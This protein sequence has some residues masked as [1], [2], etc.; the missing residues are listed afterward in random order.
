M[1]NNVVEEELVLLHIH[2]IVK[3]LDQVLDLVRLDVELVAPR[4]DVAVVPGDGR[5]GELLPDHLGVDVVLPAHDDGRVLG[6]ERSRCGNA[7]LLC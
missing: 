5:L 2:Q 4:P 1:N 7:R 6:S 3:V